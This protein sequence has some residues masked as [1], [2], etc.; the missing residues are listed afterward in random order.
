MCKGA[1]SIIFD[2]LDNTHSKHIQET[3]TNLDNYGSIGLR[4]LLCA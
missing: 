3:K 2:R 1:D 4:T